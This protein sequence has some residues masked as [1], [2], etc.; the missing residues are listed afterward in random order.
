MKKI[1]TLLLL[2]CIFCSC[3]PKKEPFVENTPGY[4]ITNDATAKNTTPLPDF[5]AKKTP[6][7]VEILPTPTPLDTEKFDVLYIT[8]S[9]VNVRETPSKDGKI[10]TTLQTNALVKGFYKENDWYYVDYGNKTYGYIFTEYVAKSPKETPPPSPSPTPIL[11]REQILNYK[12]IVDMPKSA[13]P[14]G[15]TLEMIE[16]HEYYKYVYYQKISQITQKIA[17]EDPEIGVKVLTMVAKWN[18]FNPISTERYLDL[19]EE[20]EPNQGTIFNLTRVTLTASDYKEL[21]DFLENV[22]LMMMGY[23]GYIDKQAEKTEFSKETF[24]NRYELLRDNFVAIHNNTV[25][26]A[27]SNKEGYSEQCEKIMEWYLGWNTKLYNFFDLK[28]E[29]LAELD[30]SKNQKS[31]EFYKAYDRYEIYRSYN[32][33]FNEILLIMRGETTYAKG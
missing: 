5:T 10:L 1:I 9:T 24:E 25:R 13:N 31:F 2:A 33:D 23:E 18:E 22:Y 15:T 12:P 8:G 27:D 26:E 21:L 4:N 20:F 32:Y 14:H 29:V 11:T 28:W 17:K 16:A 6:T 3:T 7:S 19:V 30:F